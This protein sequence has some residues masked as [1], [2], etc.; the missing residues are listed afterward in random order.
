MKNIIIVLFSLSLIG[1]GYYFF[2][3]IRT[4]NN[5][6]PARD[7]QTDTDYDSSRDAEVELE[8]DPS[9]D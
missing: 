6:V 9:R 5:Y 4:E 2:N 8:Y 7:T 3:Y 1:L